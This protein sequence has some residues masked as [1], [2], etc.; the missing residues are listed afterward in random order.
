MP[1][2]M[3]NTYLPIELLREIFL[4]S[5]EANQMKSGHLASVCRYWRSVITRMPHLWSTLRVD[6][7]TSMEQVTTWLQRAY[8]KKVVIDTQRYRGG[9][10]NAPAF[11]ALQDTLSTTGQ[12]HELT[13][14]SVHPQSLASHFDFQGPRSMNV[15]RALHVEAGCVHSPSLTHLLDLV[16]NGAPLSQLSLYASFASAHFL[17]PQWLPVL[18]NLTVLIVNGRD[19]HEPFDILS[20]FT[21]LHTFEADCLPLPWYELDTNL[22]LLCTL[23][24]LQ[25]KASSIQWMAGREFP[26]LEDCAILLPRHWGAIQQHEVQMPFCRKFTYHGYPITTAQYFHVPRMRAMELRSHDCRKQR[27]SQQLHHLCTVDGRISKL[28]TLHL[29]LQCSVQACI[30]MLSYL[31]LLQELILSTA[32]R[33]PSWKAFLESLVAK[34][35]RDNWPDWSPKE[36]SDLKWERWCSSQTWH[37]NILPHLKYLGIQ[38]PKGFSQSGHLDNSPLLRHIGWTRARLTPPL[39]HLKV[40]EER[41]TTSDTAVDYISTGYLDRHPGISSIKYDQIVVRGMV[42]QHLAIN[43]DT[44]PLFQLHFTALF[45]Q[46]QVL[47]IETT[48]SHEIPILPYLE[49]LK[50]L[51]I[52]GATIPTYSLSM[53]FPLVHTLQWLTLVSAP[54]SWMFGRSFKALT[55]LNIRGSQ[56]EL[57]DL[58]KHDGLLVGLPACTSLELRNISVNHLH[59]L[60]CPNVQILEWWQFTIVRTAPKSLH[61]FLHSCSCLRN[62]RFLFPQHLGA[63][64]LIQFICCDAREQGAWRD[65]KRVEINVWVTGT[66]GNNFFN[67]VVGRQRHYEKWWKEF[68]V[69]MEDFPPWVKVRVSM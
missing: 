51:V 34:P 2:N 48:S 57:K 4:Y 50:G 12:W 20:A 41:E 13:I 31:G 15:L 10:P 30:K 26:C 6:L 49:Q 55:M 32:H 46:L 54:F 43:N 67:Q 64:S 52:Q 62:L 45:R 8:P 39:E 9:L 19:I 59:F 69:T 29:T 38:C 53:D 44:T 36:I 28:T 56:D 65:I 40:W 33:S 7:W 61:D 37:A 60:S 58:P 16:P 21:R 42:T 5:I 63:D 3:I 24:K 66:S 35:S 1:K 11:T 18:Q 68:I 23:Q 47:E 17:Q 25:I 14:S 27:V 22:P